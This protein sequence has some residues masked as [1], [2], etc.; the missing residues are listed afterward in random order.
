MEEE[1]FML[2]LVQ[3]LLVRQLQAVFQSLLVHFN[4]ITRGP[5]M[6]LY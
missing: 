2:H 4:R 1:I 3:G 5:R 6:L